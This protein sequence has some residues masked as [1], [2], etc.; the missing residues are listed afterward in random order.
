[1]TLPNHD[2]RNTINAES[3]GSPLSAEFGNG[4][5]P[6]CSHSSDERRIR[7]ESPS[8]PPPFHCDSYLCAQVG[9]FCLALDQAV[10]LT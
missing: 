1:M 10:R 8:Y 9:H 5:S 6:L 4:D 2:A 3:R 7:G